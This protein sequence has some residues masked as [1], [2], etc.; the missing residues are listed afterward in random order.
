MI[1]ELIGGF[2]LIYVYYAFVVD[3]TNNM[4]NYPILCGFIY[5]LIN[6]IFC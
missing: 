2:L 5:I 3:N 1:A 4:D 6:M